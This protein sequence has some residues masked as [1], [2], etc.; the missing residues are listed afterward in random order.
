[1]TDIHNTD[2]A[3]TT[4]HSIPRE[5]PERVTAVVVALMAIGF[6]T[7]V[8]LTLPIQAGLILTTAS[9]LAWIAWMRTTYA[10][11]VR[12]RKVIAV[13]LCAVSFQ[14]IHMAEEYTGGFPHEIVDLFNSPRDWSEK[15]FLL[16]FIFGF[17]ALWVLAAAGALYQLRIA[18]YMLW[19]YALG[20]TDQR[21]LPL[22][23]PDHQG[24]LLP[25]PLHGDRSPHHERV[26]DLPPRQGVQASPSRAR[27]RHHARDGPHRRS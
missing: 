21:D 7:W 6:S 3:V 26:P 25:R 10:H 9:V 24:R 16:T 15:S 27:Q 14:F 17:G 11:P 20:R 5:R 13:Y 19:F 8:L 4:P 12:T 2:R 1:M 22:R 18:N 23:L